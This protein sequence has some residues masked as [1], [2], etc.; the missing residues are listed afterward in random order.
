MAKLVAIGLTYPYQVI[1]S[2]IQ[3]HATSHLYPNVRTCVALTYKREGVRA[4][5]KGM[6]AN[7]VRILP[8]TC[9]TFVVYENVSWALKRA[10]R[11]KA[12][13]LGAGEDATRA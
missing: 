8:A 10:A 11:A 2:R 5:Y 3:N 12:G 6:T 9:V 7:L 4:F 13:S 1:R